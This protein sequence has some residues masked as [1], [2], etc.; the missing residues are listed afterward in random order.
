MFLPF[1]ANLRHGQLLLELTM[2][3]FVRATFVRV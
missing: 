1:S 2:I 3:G